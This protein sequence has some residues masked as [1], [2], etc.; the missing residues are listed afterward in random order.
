MLNPPLFCS[1]CSSPCSLPRLPLPIPSPFPSSRNEPDQ[2]VN[3]YKPEEWLSVWYCLRVSSGL[4][5]PKPFLPKDGSSVFTTTTTT[6]ADNDDDDGEEERDD[7]TYTKQ[8]TNSSRR[9]ICIHSYCLSS[10]KE[11]IYKTPF[12]NSITHEENVLLNWSLPKWTGFGP[13]SM[14]KS[15]SGSS[16]N[17]GESTQHAYAKPEGLIDK[18][19][20]KNAIIMKPAYWGGLFDQRD[21]FAKTG[22][23]LTKDDFISPLMI[24]QP[25]SNSS[26]P[27]LTQNPLIVER[28]KQTSNL[29]KL[30]ISILTSI[31][32][33][34]LDDYA[35]IPSLEDLAILMIDD[36]SSSSSFTSLAKN[37][38]TKKTDLRRMPFLKP[39]S[40]ETFKAFSHTC[41]SLYYIDLPSNIW[42]LLILDSVKSFRNNLLQR[43]RANPTG[44]GSALYL[45]ES[46]ENNFD[47]PVNQAI[48]KVLKYQSNKQQID[49]DGDKDQVGVGRFDTSMDMDMNMKDIWFW[50]NYDKHWKSRRKVWRCV[51]HATATARDA[52]WW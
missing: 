5:D 26:F 34:I 50:W 21:R 16:S 29:L 30:P 1:I 45:W 12:S 23:H 17:G 47:H 24:P 38:H 15:I 9:I 31:F 51:V 25:D 20:D 41:L 42:L 19:G 36:A 3:R 37:N 4:I 6:T 10:I 7:E 48:S 14:S 44:V 8:L 27:L 18:K 22:D 49:L 32:Q 33:F 40:I 13:W 2:Q 43:W 11:T 35:F 46:L 28:K 52:D 39:N